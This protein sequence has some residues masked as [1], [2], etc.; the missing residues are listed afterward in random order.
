MLSDKAPLILRMGDLQ[1]C[2][3]KCI[4]SICVSQWITYIVLL[5]LTDSILQSSHLPVRS[6]FSQVPV[7]LQAVLKALAKLG[8]GT[9][10][11]LRKSQEKIHIL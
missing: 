10:R 5:V 8:N 3:W 2:I 11:G 1:H 4:Q 6:E 7:G 9:D